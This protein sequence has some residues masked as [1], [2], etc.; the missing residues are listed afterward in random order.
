MNDKETLRIKILEQI[1]N[2]EKEGIKP[3]FLNLDYQTK[4]LILSLF[5]E[6]DVSKTPYE[7]YGLKI[8]QIDTDN[9][10]IKVSGINN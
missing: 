9:T 7:L 5:E 6:V 3:F 1:R 8:S 10:F 2:L 4:Y